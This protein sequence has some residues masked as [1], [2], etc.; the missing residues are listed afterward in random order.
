MAVHEITISGV[1]HKGD[2][3]TEIEGNPVYVPFAT[4]GDRLRVELEG[5]RARI[6]DILEPGPDRATPICKHFGICG[7]CQLQHMSPEANAIWKADQVKTAFMARGIECSPVPPKCPE[8]GSRRRA[9]FSA[10]IEL[11]KLRF[12]YFERGSH[13]LI[14]ISECP[15]LHPDITSRFK[16]LRDLSTQLI[17]SSKPG[18]GKAARMSVLVTRAGLDVAVDLVPDVINNGPAY[19]RLMEIVTALDLARLTVNDEVVV[20]TRSPVLVFG[21]AIVVPPPGGFV[22]ADATIEEQMAEIILNHIGKA[23]KVVDLFAGSGT[24]S[25]RLAEKYQVWALEGHASSIAALDRA[26]R[27]CPT[28][29]TMKIE[30]RDLFRRPVMPAELKKY[31]AVVFDPPR[32]GASE[33]ATFLAKSTVKKVIAVSCNPA[34]LARDARILIDGG[35]RMNSLKPFDQFLFSPHIECVATFTRT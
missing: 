11:G 29:R 18:K 23:K 32:V 15:V 13:S 9:V 26:W 35:Y 25:L 28:L 17:K 21:K 14:S 10:K 24:F 19:L 16:G 22:Q 20:E 27:Q 1:G 2:G 6:V 31:D 4:S 12:G 33:Q 7:G 30:R 3:L 8:P 5:S 34:T